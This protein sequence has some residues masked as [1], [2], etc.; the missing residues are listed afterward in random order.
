MSVLRIHNPSDCD[1]VPLSLVH[2]L[3]LSLRMQCLFV[4]TSLRV[5]IIDLD[6]SLS[7]HITPPAPG[8]GGLF[9]ERKDMEIL[10]S[11]EERLNDTCVNRCAALLYTVHVAHEPS[12]FAVLSTHDLIRIRY[13][14]TD[15]DL[16][17]NTACTKYWEKSIW[18]LPIHHPS[19]WGHWVVCSVHFNT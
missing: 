4:S 15:E 12:L 16:W 7:T 13:N 14:A 3:S 6:I 11:H 8:F 2:N 10:T 19:S 5:S 17:R 18:I 9:F 1:L